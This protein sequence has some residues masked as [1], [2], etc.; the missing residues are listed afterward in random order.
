M[1]RLPPRV[2][3]LEIPGEGRSR[4]VGDV[5]NDPDRVVEVDTFRQVP[6]IWRCR[7]V[8][9]HAG[10]G[11]LPNVPIPNPGNEPMKDGENQ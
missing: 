1:E 4:G 10:R 8:C 5:S 11:P 3:S 9:G 7:H 6:C 2:A